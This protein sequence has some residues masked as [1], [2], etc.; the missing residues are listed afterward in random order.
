MLHSEHTR[1]Y[2]RYIH[3][4]NDVLCYI[5]NILGIILAIYV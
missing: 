3:V 5:L 4:E 2:T 1:N